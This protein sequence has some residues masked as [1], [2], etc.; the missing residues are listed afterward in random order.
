MKTI[1][2]V[3]E[4]DNLG[5]IVIPMGIR[6]RFELENDSLLEIFTEGDLLVLSKYSDKCIFC[7]SEKGV[8]EFNGKFICEK[9]KNELIN[10]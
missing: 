9:C 1:S 2:I 6:K 8:S 10:L 7:E 5:R 3:R 4:V